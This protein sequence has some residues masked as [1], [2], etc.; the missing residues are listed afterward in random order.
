[1]SDLYL[2]PTADGG[3]LVIRH[4]EP[5]TTSGLANAMY[6]SLFTPA[7]WG[8]GESERNERYRSRIP[9]LFARPL[10]ARTAREVEVAAESAL[11][12]MIRAGIAE[13]VTAESEIVGAF[14]LDLRVVI[15]E[16]GGGRRESAYA[17]NWSTEEAAAL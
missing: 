10:T 14:R 3:D 15:T 12:W 9:E 6:L 8:N 7:W 16:P 5:E 11:D 2:K 1:M 17:I 4:G 13:S